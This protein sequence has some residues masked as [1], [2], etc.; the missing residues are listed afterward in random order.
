MYPPATDWCLLLQLHQEIHDLA[1][2]RTTVHQ[3]SETDQVSPATGPLPLLIHQV[4]LAQQVNQVLVGTMRISYD[5]HPLD[6]GKSKYHVLGMGWYDQQQA[7]Q[8]HQSSQAVH[9][10]SPSTRLR[11]Q[12][13]LAANGYRHPESKCSQNIAG[14]RKIST[15]QCAIS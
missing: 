13:P 15:W 10:P 14:W 2:V 9:H 3:I 4:S 1:G 12:T 8:N 11:S 6:T 5:H 7:N